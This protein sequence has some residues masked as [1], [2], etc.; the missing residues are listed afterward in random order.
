MQ[1]KVRRVKIVNGTNTH[2]H[3]SSLASFFVGSVVERSH[4][5]AYETFLR[6]FVVLH[7][8]VFFF[9]ISNCT[10]GKIFYAKSPTMI[11]HE[12]KFITS[13]PKNHNSISPLFTV[14]ET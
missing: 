13:A 9:A 8:E 3:C 2:S 4:I 7:F 6:T 5:E 1:L 12:N 14:N 11:N 10:N